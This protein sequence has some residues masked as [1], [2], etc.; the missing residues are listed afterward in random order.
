[1]NIKLIPITIEMI[2]SLLISNDD[3]KNKYGVS[4][5][6]YREQARSDELRSES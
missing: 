5:T 6:K 4:P 1:M 3:F 2:D